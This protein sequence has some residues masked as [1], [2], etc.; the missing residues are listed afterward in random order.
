MSAIRIH[1][2]PLW[3]PGL[4]I[5]LAL[6]LLAN[7]ALSPERWIRASF[8]AV[9]VLLTWGVA[10]AV[11]VRYPERPLAMLLFALAAVQALHPA[12]SA[13]SNAFLFTLGRATRPGLELVLLWVMLAYPSGRLSDPIDRWILCTTTACVLLLWLPGV[14]F[15]PTF[16]LNG[17]YVLCNSD[18]PRNLLF[19]SDHPVLAKALFA[20]FRTAG[21]LAYLAVTLR[22]GYRLFHASALMRR[23]LLPVQM[24]SMLHLLGMMISMASGTFNWIHIL[25]FWVIPV[26]IALGLLRGRLWIARALQQL[27]SGM[28]AVP[29]RHELNAVLAQSLGDPSLQT[30]YWVTGSNHW[31]DV[32]GHPLFLPAADDSKR[33]A[34]TVTEADGS[35]VAVI[36][37]DRALQEEPALVQAVVNSMH[38]AL[39]SHQL[40]TALQTTRQRAELAAA[41]ERQR[42]ER[43]LHDG[44]QQRLIALR[45]KLAIVQQLLDVAP[46][47]ANA[48]LAEA[49][50]DIDAAL[51]ELR[52]LAHGMVPALLHEQGL[53][54]ALCELAR[55]SSSPVELSIESM[56]RPRT[57][58]EQ[59]VYFCCAEALQNAA[60]H[61]GPAAK[62][63][64]IV[65]LQAGGIGFSIADNGM[66][67]R[68]K[69][70][71]NGQGLRNMRQRVIDVGGR[72]D[73]Q[74]QSNGGVKV[75]GW[76]PT[77]LVEPS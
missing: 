61:A 23:V 73:I 38:V 34:H 9:S 68:G 53:S 60:K 11:R 27:V 65:T 50:L 57:E 24:V 47:R 72:L 33:I 25:T 46:F 37:H 32:H 43:D 7:E 22:L 31:M 26:A 15:T 42:I 44:A 21:V 30:G 51:T 69:L 56:P 19:V 4:A 55:L 29:D 14:L 76:V 13:S 45:V 39:S 62:V 35:P 16:L 64:M 6:T 77:K 48:L 10:V 28:R 49:G 54:V 12:L 8:S 1:L 59:A 20:A 36:L 5:T 41:T 75:S 52:D 66:E 2:S 70:N 3:L 71:S 63:S 58:I 74:S 67:S 17:P 40:A 18:C